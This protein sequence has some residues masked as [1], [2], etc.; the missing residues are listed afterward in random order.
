MPLEPPEKWV[1]DANNQV[2]FERYFK[3]QLAPWTLDDLKVK[4]VD[5]GVESEE[6]RGRELEG[7]T[8]YFDL[9]GK[10]FDKRISKST[11]ENKEKA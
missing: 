1:D 3:N 2:E 4:C 8:G 6:V 9:C 10:C 5:C 7:W 11:G